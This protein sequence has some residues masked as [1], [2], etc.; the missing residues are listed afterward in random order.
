MSSLR[1]GEVITKAV[2]KKIWERIFK[3]DEYT[4]L[5]FK[6]KANVAK[7]IRHKLMKELLGFD[8]SLLAKE[9]MFEE[10]SQGEVK[11]LKT[12]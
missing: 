8:P 1:F 10:L 2:Q 5:Q 12:I 9:C 11:P 7:E 6:L 4:N 3:S